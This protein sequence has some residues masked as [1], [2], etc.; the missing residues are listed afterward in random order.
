MHVSMTHK[1]LELNTSDFVV[2]GNAIISTIPLPKG[3]KIAVK[4][5]EYNPSLLNVPGTRML[6]FTSFEMRCPGNLAKMMV[7][8]NVHGSTPLWSLTGPLE[9]GYLFY[10][11]NKDT[12][13]P[14]KCTT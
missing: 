11:L 5:T 8:N 14:S 4:T 12:H 6:S 3:T 10:V 2:F 7:T 9:N 1:G 13:G